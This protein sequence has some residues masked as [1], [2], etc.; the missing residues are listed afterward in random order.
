[1]IMIHDCYCD[2]YIGILCTF[3]GHS[4]SLIDILIETDITN[5]QDYAKA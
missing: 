3:C 4:Y 1:M 5:M 2:M